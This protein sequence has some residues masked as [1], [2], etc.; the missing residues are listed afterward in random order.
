MTDP[1]TPRRPV[2]DTYHGTVVTDDYR[3]LEDW[4]SQ[5]VQAWSEAQNAHARA[6]LDR[7]P[8]VA[9]LRD[10]LTKIMAAKTTTHRQFAARAGRLFALRRQPPKQQPFLVVMP[11]PDTPDDAQVLLDPNALDENGTTAIDWFV[12]SP[13]GRLVAV[14]LSK[15]GSE[16]GDV[17]VYDVETGKETDAV[18]P[19]RPRRHGRRRPGLGADGRGFFYTRYPRGTERPAEDLDFYQQVYYHALGTPADADRYELGKDLPRIA[20]FRLETDVPTGRVLA[21]VQNGDGGEFAFFVRSP[22]GTWQRIAG[23]KDGLV[24]AAFGPDG[25]VFAVSRRD[26]P[27]GQSAAPAADDLDLARA[28]VVVPEGERRDRHRLLRVRRRQDRPA[29]RLAALRHLPAR[30]PDA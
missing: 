17:H 1:P 3:W 6:T 29:V 8:G 18:G 21:T 27:R 11:A 5:E 4:S 19:A 9:V 14:S 7:L 30:R 15:G 22:D 24:Q 28:T 2:T 26:A 25:D 10:R 20:E 23:F 13:D 12:P 16:S